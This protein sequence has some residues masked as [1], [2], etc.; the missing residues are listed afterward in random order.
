V[1]NAHAEVAGDPVDVDEGRFG[2]TGRWHGSSSGFGLSW[3]LRRAVP[4][5]FP[6]AF[7]V[8]RFLQK[9]A[10]VRPGSIPVGP[11]C[12]SGWAAH[13]LAHGTTLAP[14]RAITPRREW[15]PGLHRVLG[16]CRPRRY[17]QECARRI[18]R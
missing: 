11:R 10:G 2:G 13:C 4:L 12:P 15:G 16:R 17:L 1:A 18:C 9:S 3:I 7:P 5:A 14:D 6:F 8:W